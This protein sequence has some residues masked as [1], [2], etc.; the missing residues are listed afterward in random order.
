[1]IA[2][3]AN[4]NLNSR[5]GS[6]RVC[7]EFLEVLKSEGFRTKVLTKTPLDV[8]GLEK[9]KGSPLLIDEVSSFE[10]F[11]LRIF[12]EYRKFLAMAPLLGRSPDVFANTSGD[13][14]PFLYTKSKVNIT[15]CHF[16]VV[17]LIVNGHTPQKYR[18]G[19][20]ASY[21]RLH[22]EI[23]NYL[24]HG[25]G[26]RVLFIANSN[27]TRE[28]MRQSLH[29]EPRVVYPPVNINEFRLAAES[30]DREDRV[31]TV[32][33]FNPSKQLELIVEIAKAL[34]HSIRWDIVGSL[35]R[36]NQGYFRSLR[37]AI[38]V[39]GL[40]D[41]VTLRPNA[42]SGEI[43]QLFRKARVYFH[44]KRGEHF[45]ISIVEAMASGLI[46][47]VWNYGGCSEIVPPRWQFSD[48]EEAKQ[49]ILDGMAAS[50]EERSSM[51]EEAAKYSSTRF[52]SEVR[53]IIRSVVK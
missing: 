22:A 39:R 20:W 6:S 36:E 38:N 41:R 17:S 29:V 11:R 28:A 16:P 4:R 10:P 34:P 43:I 44:P 8:R 32:S 21:Y 18:R 1:M 42:S 53:E 15:Y 23:L 33:R 40:A 31:V 12:E 47:V 19:L 50:S 3:V 13:F 45:G 37:E 35:D 52:R 14:Y 49:G 5:G 30:Q 25:A 48:L 46:P 9:W 2:L 24:I 27:F 26:A 7:L 51:S